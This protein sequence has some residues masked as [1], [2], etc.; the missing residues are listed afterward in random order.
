MRSYADDDS[1]PQ[2]RLKQLIIV[3]RFLKHRPGDTLRP[4]RASANKP[5]RLVA[6]ENSR[7]ETAARPAAP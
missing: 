2:Q 1:S 7:K 5:F 6:V 3:P 4:P